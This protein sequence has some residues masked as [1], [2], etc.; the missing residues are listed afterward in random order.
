MG[1]G[2]SALDKIGMPN[3]I[4]YVDLALGKPLNPEIGILNLIS[5]Y[6]SGSLVWARALVRS[7]DAN[8]HAGLGPRFGLPNPIRFARS[9][10]K[11][12]LSSFSVGF[13]FIN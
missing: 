13:W 8:Q 9:D 6:Q 10:P 3:S 5:V 11:P 2:L 12:M 1:H 4:R 7:I